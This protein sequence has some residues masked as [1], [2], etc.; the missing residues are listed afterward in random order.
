MSKK[1]DGHGHARPS[2]FWYDNDKDLLKRRFSLDA[3]Q[4]TTAVLPIDL[5][6]SPKNHNKFKKQPQ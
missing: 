2:F 6:V 4:Y 5:D 1:K 3:R